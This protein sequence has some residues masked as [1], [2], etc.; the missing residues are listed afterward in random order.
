MNEFKH[1]FDIVEDRVI[2]KVP[3]IRV[4]IPADYLTRGIAEVDGKDLKT[5]GI[6]Y[7]D[8]Y[9]EK[10]SEYDEIGRAHV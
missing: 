5:M 8:V 6:F 4:R 10:S 1:L 7:F 9:G 2:V 3:Y